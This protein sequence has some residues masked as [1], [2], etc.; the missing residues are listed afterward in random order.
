MERDAAISGEPTLKPPPPSRFGHEQ[1]GG[2]RGCKPKISQNYPIL[3]HFPVKI[4]G[5]IKIFSRLRRAI[6]S[7]PLKNSSLGTPQARKNWVFALY[8]SGKV[9]KILICLVAR[10]RREKKLGFRPVYKR[11]SDENTVCSPPQARKKMPI[12]ANP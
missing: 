9:M 4:Q 10:R 3:K 6:P 1:R 7:I 11:E 5:A 8:T 2:F 12:W